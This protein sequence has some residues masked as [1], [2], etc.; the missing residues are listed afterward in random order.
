MATPETKT[1]ALS[2]EQSALKDI[3]ANYLEKFGFHD[4]E[5]GYAYK[6]P[7]GLSEQVVRDISAYTS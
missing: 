3:G 6:S 1:K 7:K 5:S 2:D 4:S